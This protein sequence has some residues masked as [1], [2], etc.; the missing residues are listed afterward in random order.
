MS[1]I[2][3]VIGAPAETK[4][5]ISA[6]LTAAYADLGMPA[7]AAALV[8]SEGIRMIAE[9]TAAMARLTGHSRVLVAG[10]RVGAGASTVA[11]AL[12][13][14][15]AARLGIETLL[16]GAGASQAESK[17]GGNG[18]PVRIDQSPMAHLWTARCAALADAGQSAAAGN[19]ERAERDGVLA[20]L[21]QM[22]A[23]YRA[24]VVD[25]GAV[26]LDPRMLAVARP[27][28]PVLV[29]ARYGATRRDE[30]AGTVAV[31]N[32]AKCRIG[33]VILNSYESPALDRLQ[34][35]AGLGR[36]T[37]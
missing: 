2:S 5:A 33:G 16:V 4:P 24:A 21:Q 27:D 11:G 10:C 15:L 36:S 18:R 25:L 19:G 30:L 35:I 28:D 31:I 6:P 32:L 20:E 22:I 26:R 8:D 14:D 17:T 3:Q 7:A 1:N 9:P 37:R 13:L 12:A 23:R 34:W 29:V